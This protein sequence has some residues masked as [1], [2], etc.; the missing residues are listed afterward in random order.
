MAISPGGY[1]IGAPKVLAPPKYGLFNVIPPK[2]L[3]DLHA[4]AGGVWWRE[5]LCTHIEAFIDQCPP[6]QFTKSKEKDLEFCYADP[7]VVKGSFTCSPVGFTPSEAFE[8][9]R[10]RL[11]AWES[12]EVEKVLWT[13]VTADGTVNP[14]FAFGNTSCGITPVDLTPGGP[15]TPAA[16]LALLENALTAVVPGGGI[17]FAPYGAASFFAAS[18]ILDKDGESYYTKTG[19]PM[20]FGAGF[21]GSGIANAVAP[22]GATTLFA[23]GPMAVWNSNVIMVP[24]ELG[25]TVNRSLNDITVYAERFYSVGFSC[26]LFKV[27]MELTCEC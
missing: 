5:V 22:S 14:S 2:T 17:V 21:P 27:D 10:K 6:D 9:A 1:E 23:T 7:F 20:V 13:G 26:A 16:A 3:P 25:E 12:F 18:K 4:F 11:L 19:Y 8:I 24:D 15:V